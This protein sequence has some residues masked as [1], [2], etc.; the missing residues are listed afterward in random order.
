MQARYAP[1]RPHVVEIIAAATA[2]WIVGVA[3]WVISIAFLPANG[4]LNIRTAHL[5]PCLNRVDIRCSELGGH[6]RRGCRGLHH[7]IRDLH[8]SDQVCRCSPGCSEDRAVAGRRKDIANRA[9]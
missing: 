6:R 4:L 7:P 5:V 8:H 2:N 3:P 9:G 1:L